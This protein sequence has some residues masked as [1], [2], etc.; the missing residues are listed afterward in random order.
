MSSNFKYVLYESIGGEVCLF[1]WA[2]WLADMLPMCG[3]RL[4]IKVGNFIDN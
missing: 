2:P 3:R 4:P 1:L